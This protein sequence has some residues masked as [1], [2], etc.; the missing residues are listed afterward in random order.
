MSSGT[1][2]SRRRFLYGSAVV[3][4][5]SMLAACTSSSS[6]SGRG[7]G[8]RCRP[9]HGQ[10]LGEK[11]APGSEELQ[12]VTD[13]GQ[14]GQVRQDGGGREAAARSSPYVVPHNWVER[15]KYGGTLNMIGVLQ[16]GHGQGG[17]QPRILLRPLPVAMGE[18]RTGHLAGTRRRPGRRTPTHRSGPCTSVKGLKWSDGTAFT[19]DDVL[20]WWEDIIIPGHFAQMPP[21]DCR[22]A[23]GTLCKMAKVDDLT[24]KMTFDAPAADRRRPPRVLRQGRDRHQRCR[25]G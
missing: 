16:P 4:G 7:R 15:G 9:E 5:S 21:D 22:S 25:S 24:L 6:S 19:V 23:N 1:G 13:P 11:A 2:L 12:R 14:P 17:L 20:F 10:G 3:A 18:R 8:R